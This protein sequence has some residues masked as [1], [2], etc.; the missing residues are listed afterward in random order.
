VL[1]V[2]AVVA[3]G[4]WNAHL[5]TRVGRAERLQANTSQLIAAVSHPSSRIV[6]LAAPGGGAGA[7]ARVAAAY[8]PGGE[9]LFVF[10]SMPAPHAERVYQ[11]WMRRQG[12]YER[13][14]AFVPNREGFVL[15]RVAV[16]P[17]EYDAVLITE[18]SGSGSEQPSTVQVAGSDL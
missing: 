14:G 4:A 16:D 3:L 15:L 11:V 2:A 5:L 17:S 10:G 7:A 12:V 8:V 6:P 1:A 13:A 9:A 18:E